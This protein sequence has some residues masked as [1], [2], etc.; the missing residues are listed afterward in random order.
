MNLNSVAQ[1]TVRR[2]TGRQS[3]LERL[4]VFLSDPRYIGTAR[5]ERA[6]ELLEIARARRDGVN[7]ER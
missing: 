3:L 7:N 2:L 6:N 1:R 4:T 5:W